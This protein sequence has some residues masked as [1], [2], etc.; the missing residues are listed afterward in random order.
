[1]NLISLIPTTTVKDSF[2]IQDKEILSILQTVGTDE[3]FCNFVNHDVFL[4]DHDPEINQ[5]CFLHVITESTFDYPHVN[6][7][8]KTWKPIVNLR[9]FILVGPAGLLSNLQDLGFQT[10]SQWWD[11]SYDHIKDPLQRMLAIV[12]Q[13]EMIANKSLEDLNIMYQ[14]MKSILEHNFNHYYKNFQEQALSKFE[15]DCKLNLLPR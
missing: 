2:R 12:G 4:Y 9:P 13:I 8:E 10:F 5:S 14:E 3:I 11:E 1:M 7:S 15:N 6:Y